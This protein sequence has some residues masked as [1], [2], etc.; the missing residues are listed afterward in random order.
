MT[1]GQGIAQALAG[2]ALTAAQSENLLLGAVVPEEFE[3]I[4]PLLEPHPLRMRETLQ[5]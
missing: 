4:L 5:E 3:R 2:S 1:D